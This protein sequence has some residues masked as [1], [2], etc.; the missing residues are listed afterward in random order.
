MYNTNKALACK[1]GKPPVHTNLVSLVASVPSLIIA[2][3]QIIKNKSACT[4]GAML[5]FPRARKL[6]SFQRRLISSS[7]NSPDGISYQL[8]KDTSELLKQGK[9]PW[10]AS[11]RIYIDK[12]G[13]PDKKRPIPI[14][15]FMDRVVQTS[16]LKGLECTY[17]SWFE[18]QNRSFSFRSRKG[19]HDAIYGLTRGENKGLHIA[20]EGDI[21]GTYD[22]VNRSKF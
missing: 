1:N 4:L 14:P 9:N 11:R 19:V 3:R 20:I 13:Q 18:I 17:S 10:S 7:A 22:N 16:I 2:Y 6:N 8:F 5:S 15:T 12:P 21:K